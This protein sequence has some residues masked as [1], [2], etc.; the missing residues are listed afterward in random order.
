MLR[1]PKERHAAQETQKQR[2]IAQRRQAAADIGHDK[3]EEHKSVHL[4]A[5]PF[6]GGQQRTNQ[7]HSRTGR[8]HEVSNKS[9]HKENAG[10]DDRTTDEAAADV[11]TARNNKKCADEQNKGNVVTDHGVR[12][13]ADCHVGR[14]RHKDRNYAGQ[15]PGNGN[16]AV[17][18]V[19]QVGRDER[20]K[21]NGQKNARKRNCPCNGE[22]GT[23]ETSCRSQ[24]RQKHRCRC[25]KYLE[26]M[27]CL[28]FS[29]H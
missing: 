28:C 17:V 24:G 11:N 18:V 22:L 25:Q 20:H 1:S 21:G 16:L 27:H 3:N 9:P 2:R 23:V 6:V 29:V 10:I 7:Q 8:P 14:K 15:P 26:C 19:P 12:N 4:V 13:R 5:T